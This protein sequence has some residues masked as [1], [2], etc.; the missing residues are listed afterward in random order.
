MSS[1]THAGPSGGVGDAASTGIAGISPPKT[2]KELNVAKPTCA[3]DPTAT[4]AVPTMTL[5]V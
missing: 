4:A 3:L 2:V 1:A 5:G